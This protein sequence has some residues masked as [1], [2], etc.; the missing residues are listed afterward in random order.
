MKAFYSN[1]KSK[2]LLQK[3]GIALGIG[4][5]LIILNSQKIIG[6]WICLAI[7][8]LLIVYFII[9]HLLGEFIS[10][11]NLDSNEKKIELC[12]AKNNAKGSHS[13]F[14]TYEET[15]FIYQYELISR[16]NSSPVLSIYSGK[17]PQAK[18][19]EG[20]DWDKEVLKSI[21][22]ELTDTGVKGKITK[23]TLAQ[24]NEFD[25]IN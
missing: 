8:F 10:A 21:I 22:K 11:V 12:Y 7:L 14:Q 6:I 1:T 24:T 3:F 2:P 13:V 5:L 9:D 16:T 20:N 4:L 18:L 25:Y 19:I 23:T 17:I 15:Y